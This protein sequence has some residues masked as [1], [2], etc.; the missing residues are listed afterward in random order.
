MRTSEEVLRQFNTRYNNI[1][2]GAAPGI[3]IFE[4]SQYLTEAQR[5][6]VNEYYGGTIVKDNSFES[7]E[8]V[9]KNITQLIKPKEYNLTLSSTPSTDSFLCYTVKYGNEVWRVVWESVLIES[10]DICLNE[11]QLKVFPVKHDDLVYTLENP[12]RRPS[13]KRVLRLDLN[14]THEIISKYTIIKYM[15][16]VLEHPK[17]FIIGDLIQFGNESGLSETLTIEGVSTISLCE[18]DNFVE[19]IIINRAI[20]LAISD[21]KEE[22][23]QAKAQMNLRAE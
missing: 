16:R 1:N 21:Y 18:F 6:I 8:K 13:D 3:N 2:S 20:E 22:S 4:I 17:P 7:I 15:C 9:R 10:E 5:Q 19:D 11:K 23:L 12:F 14:A